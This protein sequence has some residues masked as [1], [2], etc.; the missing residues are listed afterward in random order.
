MNN[1]ACKAAIFANGEIKDADI[2]RLVLI[3]WDYILACDG[4]LRH[5]DAA[6]IVPDYIVGDLDSVSEELLDKYQNVPV[7]RFFAEKDQTDLELAIAH[8][9]DIGAES[10]VV[11]GGLGGRVDHQLA[12]M[13]VLAQ[14]VERGVEAEIWDWSRDTRIKLIKNHCRLHKTNGTLVTLIPLTT[15]VD[16]IVTE[17]LKYPLKNES[18]IVGFARGVSNQIIDEMALVSLKSGLLL[19]IQ[20]KSL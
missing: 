10:I 6:G 7:L 8:A 2:T 20:T 11:F 13:H 16:G 3:D 19:V 1:L 18:L 17:G 15:T 5:C 9:C 4:G 14:A 12:N